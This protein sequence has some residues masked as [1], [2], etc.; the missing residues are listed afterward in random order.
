VVYWRANGQ[1]FRATG[2]NPDL[3]LRGEALAA[4]VQTWT[5]RL[6]FTDGTEAPQADNG[7]DGNAN[8]DYDDI[9]GL[10]IRATLQSDR[11]DPKVNGG[12]P[13]RRDLQWWYAPRNLVYERNR[14]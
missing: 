2:F 9:A 6:V 1:L 4:G 3:T 5:G 12:Q 14:M 11:I 10:R 7:S 8:N 13:V